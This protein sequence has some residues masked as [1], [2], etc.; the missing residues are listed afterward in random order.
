MKCPYRNNECKELDTS[1]MTKIECV[2]CD[3]YK[4][5]NNTITKT[6]IRTKVN[7]SIYDILEQVFIISDTDNLKDDL[8][9]DSLDIVDL[10]LHLES[11]FN[12]AFT[13]EE[14][15]NWICV[16][17]ILNTIENRINE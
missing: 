5:D 6:T 16:K 9:I 3:W 14:I 2:K 11:E 4:Q 15:K 7:E 8:N 17:D 13:D 1:S 12:I 10:S